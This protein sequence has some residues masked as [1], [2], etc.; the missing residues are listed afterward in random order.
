[1]LWRDFWAVRPP[2]FELTAEALILLLRLALVA[3][4]YLFLASIAL[5]AARDNIL[6]NLP[7]VAVRCQVADYTREAL[8]LNR[9]T[10]TRTLAL[11]IGSSIGISLVI[12]LLTR[13]TKVVRIFI[14]DI[15]T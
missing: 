9:L 15:T 2:M 14:V 10:N 13:N 7:G 1:M 3:L 8:P 11:Y 12:V 4:I 6:T 5:A